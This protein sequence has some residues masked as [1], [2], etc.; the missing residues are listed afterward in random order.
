VLSHPRDPSNPRFN[1][2]FCTYL[3]QPRRVRTADRSVHQN[4]DARDEAAA[5]HIDPLDAL[6]DGFVR[7][8]GFATGQIK[9][10]DE[11]DSTEIT[12]VCGGSRR[13]NIT[14]GE[15]GS[16]GGA[17]Q[18]ERWSAPLSFLLCTFIPRAAPELLRFLRLLHLDAFE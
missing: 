18:H 5:L 14:R 9:A 15:R 2:W 17:A 11:H 16:L 12:K 1:L 13:W 4:S 10:T 8:P 7:R 3:H 6:P